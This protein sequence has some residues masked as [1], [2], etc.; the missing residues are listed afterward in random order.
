MEFIQQNL[1]LVA[2]AVVSGTL[3]L[4]LSFR[5]PG[6]ARSL[7][8]AQATLLINRENAQL[9]DVREPNEYV[10][11]HP[12]DSR[13]IPVG[14]LVERADELAQFK[15]TPVILI[16]QSGARS[17]SACAKLAK[18]G[19]TRLHSLEGGITAWAEAGLPLKKGSRR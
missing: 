5:R 14:S 11:G 2:V 4:G 18:L 9:L 3:L 1:L 17:S 19:F 13:N 16:C 10:A 12:S 7:T 6:G 15:D 8:P